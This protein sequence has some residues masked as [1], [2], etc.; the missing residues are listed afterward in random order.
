MKKLLILIISLGFLFTSCKTERIVTK[1]EYKDSIVYKERWDTLNVPV[2]VPAE[3]IKLTHKLPPGL[4]TNYKAKGQIKKDHKT[5]KYE[6]ED[7]EITVE[8]ND[9]AYM[10]TIKNLRVKVTDLELYKSKSI[11]ETKLK[12]VPVIKYKTPT[13]VKWYIGGTVLLGLVLAYIKGWLKWPIAI[14]KK[15]VQFIIKLF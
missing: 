3:G 8:S 2:F 13:W 5:V 1:T 10:D 11:E 7:G 15:A 4:P 14:I 9:E 6:I 12:E